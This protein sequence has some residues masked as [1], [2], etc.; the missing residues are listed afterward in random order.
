ML[1]IRKAYKREVQLVKASLDSFI[2][3]LTEK[4]R[5]VSNDNPQVYFDSVK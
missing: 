3:F 2:V 4:Y 1:S 5:T